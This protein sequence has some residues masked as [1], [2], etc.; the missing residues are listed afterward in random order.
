MNPAGYGSGCPPLR[1]AVPEVD[2]VRE[3]HV[4]GLHAG[5]GVVYQTP[6]A[7]K[8]LTIET[9]SSATIIPGGGIAQGAVYWAS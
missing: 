8:I 6:Y 2:D 4:L 9:A 3:D 5:V 1:I 7:G